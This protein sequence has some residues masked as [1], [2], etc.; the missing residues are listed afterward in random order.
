MELMRTFWNRDFKTAVT[1]KGLFWGCFFRTEN[2][3]NMSCVGCKN[4]LDI[5]ENILSSQGCEC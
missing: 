1:E 2:G 5:S 4:W 3:M